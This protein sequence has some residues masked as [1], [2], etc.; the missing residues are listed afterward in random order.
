MLSGNDSYYTVS[1]K[2][3]YTHFKYF[4]N[5]YREHELVVCAL[6][7]ATVLFPVIPKNLYICAHRWW[8]I[9]CTRKI[10]E[11]SLTQR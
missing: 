5:T 1:Q 2:K 11:Q 6:E 8:T 9:F 7:L 4:V 3:T 10:L